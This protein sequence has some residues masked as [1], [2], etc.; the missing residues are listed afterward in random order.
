MS[1]SQVKPG[2]R[3]RTA[4]DLITSRFASKV[5]ESMANPSIL[6]LEIVKSTMTTKPVFY[7][8]YLGTEF[9]TR[10]CVFF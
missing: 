3:K 2:P 4:T 6:I 8:V 5:L 1:P 7:S 10:D 9:Q